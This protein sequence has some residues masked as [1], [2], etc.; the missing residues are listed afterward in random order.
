LI[1][2]AK[3][4]KG[5]QKQ[6]AGIR[7]RDFTITAKTKARYE[8]AV[9][10]I[11]PFLEEQESLAFI[12]E[13]VMDWMELQ[14]CKGETVNNIA[15]CLSGLH[16]F[17]PE[18]KGRLRQSW[19]LFKSWRR[20]EC[21]Q[22][23]AP[24]TVPIVCAVI[25]RALELDALAFAALIALSFHCMLRTGEAL[26]LQLGDEVGICSL[27]SSK[28]GLRTG[29]EEAVSIRDLLVL[30]LL[31]TLAMVGGSSRSVAACHKGTVCHHES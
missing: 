10:L 2:A 20:I 18:Y 11:L 23:A 30:D 5:R 4:R 14:W 12:D 17:C 1:L 26:A 16:W 13:V 19:K 24:L 6:R 29:S 21:P 27:Y 15:D 31:R 7:L 8:S 28:S 9:A 22:K 3:T 25:A